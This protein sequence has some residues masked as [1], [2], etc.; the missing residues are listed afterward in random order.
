MKIIADRPPNYHEII[1]ALPEVE[2]VPGAIFSYYPNIYYPS[3]GELPEYKIA[4][5]MVHLNQQVRIGV[6]KWW[7]AFLN[8][9]GFRLEQ[10]LEAYRADYKMFCRMYKD[11]NERA[12]Y[13][14]SLVYDLSGPQYGSIV[15][16]DE[17]R[18][19]LLA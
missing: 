8:S 5:E 12:R 14:Q 13:L 1:A 4:H 18:S 2:H 15:L 17:V 9:S 10:E 6:K 11:G 7:T 3:G 16:G 19:M